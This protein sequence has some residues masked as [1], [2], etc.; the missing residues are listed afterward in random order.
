MKLVI[1]DIPPSS[2]KYLGNS[3]SY[4]VYRQD[5]ERW[6]WLVKAAIRERPERPMGR[7]AVAL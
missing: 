7:A 3:H 6:H 1:G 5:K 2:N 4:H